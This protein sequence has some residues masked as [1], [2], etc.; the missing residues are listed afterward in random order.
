MSNQHSQRYW[1]ALLTAV[2]LLMQSF[3]IWHDAE[4]AFHVA[5]AAEEQCERFEAFG[6]APTLDLVASVSPLYTTQITV[7]EAVPSTPL[8]TSRQ[9]ETYAIRAPPVPSF[10]S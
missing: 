7:V 8:L 10:F 9:R 3:A 2:M 5:E 6:H 4:H 1:L